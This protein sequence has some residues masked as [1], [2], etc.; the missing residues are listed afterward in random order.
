MKKT[1]FILLCI[2]L[3]PSSADF[4]DATAAYANK[5]YELAYHEFKRLAKIGNKRA[6]FNLGVMYLNGEYVENDLILAYAWGKLSEHKAR[7]EFTQI[8]QTIAQQLN[9]K[10]LAKA[11]KA[12]DDL[13]E[14]YGEAQI[15]SQLSPIVYQASTKKQKESPDYTA[16]TIERKA[17]RYPKEAYYDRLQGWV[18]VG[19]EIHPDGTARNPYV[20]DAYPPNVFE[21]A[22]LKAVQKFKFNVNFKSGVDPYVT[23]ARQTFEYS[24][25]NLVNANKLR[26]YYDER[27]QQLLSL[28]KQ[29]SAK[30]QYLYAL[31]ASSNFINKNNK[32]SQEE[33]NEW[34]L[35]SAQNGHLEAQ[36][37]LGNNILRGKGC[38]VEKQKAVDWIV[39]A[40]EQGHPKSSR[41][42]Y[43]LLT[44]NNHL[45]N[46]NKP[47]EYWLKQAAKNGDADSQIDY[48]EYLAKQVNADTND[49][50]LARTMLEKQ[51]DQRDKSVK[52]YQISAMI[53][54]LQG[55]SKKA[56]KHSKKADKL[57]KKLGWKS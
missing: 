52:W 43:Q 18:T 46:T 31:A 19:F 25:E 14:L 32:M 7:P 37:H 34:L 57:A 40:A 39:Y 48:A 27:L 10:E 21:S 56:N 1:I 16:E 33:V 49:L 22:T 12:Y 55:D 23:Y 26:Q 9:P 3:A 24:L 28:A 30:S 13:D 51:A 15:Y 2:Y 6:Q 8:S 47:P 53:Y 4:D 17:P 5:Q 29:G 45:N 11:E 38:K 36:Y 50:K 54:Q 35:K 20:M 42:A 44:K 41:K